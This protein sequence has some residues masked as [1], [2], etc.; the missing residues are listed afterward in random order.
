[1]TEEEIIKKIES[2]GD[3]YCE[4]HLKDWDNETL[5]SS[6]WEA[7][8]FFFAH[9]YFRG[10]RDELSNEYRYFT[11]QILGDY[12]FINNSDLTTAYQNLKQSRRFYG[13]AWILNFKQQKY[14]G[15]GNSIKHD[16]FG[17]DVADRNPLVKLLTTPKVVEIRWDEK[18]YNKELFLGNDEDVMMVLD[19]LD[20][21]SND[22]K[23]NFYS[24]LKQTITDFGTG[25]AYKELLEIR[26]VAD[27]IASFTIRDIGLMNLGIVIKDYKMAFP[28]DTW[29]FQKA[30]ELGCSSENFDE[31]KE[32]LIL[33]CKRYNIHPLKFA[34]GL[35]MWGFNNLDLEG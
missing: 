3:L 34:A 20:I 4:D 25:K 19:I 18:R 22:E 27:K 9:S 23:K 12:F 29:V 30:K 2:F 1:M 26:A 31:V 28:V 8:K 15:I 13:K 21:I 10:R 7:L 32:F 17:K 24:Y 6:W 35:W 14:L 11:L 33:K 16:D 5:E